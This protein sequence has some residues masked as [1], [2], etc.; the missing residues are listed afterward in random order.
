MKNSTPSY[1]DQVR[2][3]LRQDSQIERALGASA[4]Q[5]IRSGMSQERTRIQAEDAM[6]IKAWGGS[7]S[8]VPDMAGDVDLG[9]NTTTYNITEQPKGTSSFGKLAGAALLAGSLAVP[10]AAVAWKAFDRPPA[11]EY[12]DRDSITELQI[13]RPG[14]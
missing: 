13:Y 10:T 12:S 6:A 9:G 3:G 7:L 11:P 4:L 5:H 14:P 1:A 8:E 2:A